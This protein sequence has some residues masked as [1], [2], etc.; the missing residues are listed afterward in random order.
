MTELGSIFEPEPS[1][2]RG[3]DLHAD[4]TVPAWALGLSFG[5]EVRVPLDLAATGGYARRVV[6]S[7]DADDRLRLS[8]PAGLRSGSTLRLRGQG[9]ALAD[10][11]PGD[12][13]VRVEV[14]AARTDPPPEIR[15]ALAAMAAAAPRPP[16]SSP[17][18][19][20]QTLAQI[21]PRLTLALALIVGLAVALAMIG[22]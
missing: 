6:S 20:P 12:L 1:G 5:Y 14:D 13:L 15:A 10:G 7:F 19:A 22:R 4:V 18:A 21:L 3:R 8:L 9:E 11:R 17:F 2:P 16:A